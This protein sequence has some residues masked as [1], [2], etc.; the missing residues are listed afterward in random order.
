[1][2]TK[3]L[4]ELVSSL[5]P[6]EQAVV[7]QFI[8]FLKRESAPPHSSFL[9]AIDEFTERHAELLERLSR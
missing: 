5:N 4:P 6:E 3:S 8:E 1:M 7:R 9:T 2:R